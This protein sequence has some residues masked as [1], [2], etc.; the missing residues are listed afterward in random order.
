MNRSGDLQNCSKIA[1][2]DRS[3]QELSSGTNIIYTFDKLYMILSYPNLPK[4]I[5]VTYP[6]GDLGSVSATLLLPPLK[7]CREVLLNFYT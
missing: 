7:V 5:W 4:S 3:R 6:Q 1:P 2:F